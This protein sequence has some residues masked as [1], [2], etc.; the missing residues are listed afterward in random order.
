MNDLAAKYGARF[1]PAQ[2]LKERAAG[3]QKFYS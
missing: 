1:K 2:I 3:S